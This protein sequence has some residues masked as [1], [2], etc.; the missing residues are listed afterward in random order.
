MQDVGVGRWLLAKAEILGEE[1]L[2]EMQR[3]LPL[4]REGVIA[5]G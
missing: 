5:Y 4:L 2:E 1:L 3:Q